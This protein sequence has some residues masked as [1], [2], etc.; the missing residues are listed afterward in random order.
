MVGIACLQE[1]CRKSL[2]FRVFWLGCVMIY[3]FGE[4]ELDVDQFELRVN[5]AR[6]SVEPQVFVIL[7]LLI[8][9]R[10]RM[11][12]KS[13]LMDAVWNGR[14]VSEGAVSSRIRSAR[15]AV[16]DTG[17]AQRI[18][19]TVHG[20]G[21]R[22]VADVVASG[23]PSVDRS[24]QAV[25]D[26]F[27]GF[28]NE[29]PN[30]DFQFSLPNITGQP[31]IAV[32]PFDQIT[33]STDEAI[34]AKGLTEETIANLT[35]F[36]DLFVF[37]RSTTT[38]L[39]K[40]GADI[41]EL[42]RQLGVDFVLE[43]SVRLAGSK[44]KITIQLIDAKSDIHVFA[45]QYDQHASPDSLYDLQD[46]VALLVAGRIADRYGPLSKFAVERNRTGQSEHWNTYLQISR[47]YDYYETR[48]ASIHASVKAGLKAAL[49]EDRKSS[50][51]WAALALLHVDE[52]RLPFHSDPKP[53]LL[54]LALDYAEKSVACD[55]EN[56]FAYLARA[57]A[58]FHRKEFDDFTVAAKR[59]VE[60]NPG[61]AHNLAEIAF[62]YC[63]VSDFEQALPLADRAV[64]LSPVHPGWFRL[65]RACFHF[66]TEKDAAAAIAEQKKTPMEGYFWYHAYMVA[67]CALAGDDDLTK[68]EVRKILELYPDFPT[69]VFKEAEVW[70][71]TGAMPLKMLKGWRIAGLDVQFPDK[72][73]HLDVT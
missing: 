15:S 49:F 35:R 30:T 7:R 44:I 13:E 26:A 36:K 55:G 54:D 24:D 59:C 11:V 71:V 52:Y 12:S 27:A 43:G 21:L 2:D 3:T 53:E 47:F 25:P 45:E 16:G 62:C 70:C 9:N 1:I 66:V 69:R 41:P 65:T 67:Y 60:I 39:V 64:E 31:S 28:S 73:R 22:F 33:G 56:S 68:A 63:L 18:I 6:I 50:D 8:E 20:Q 10:E 37:S 42:Q 46:H 34:F 40:D 51:A 58:R 4:F 48:K 23:K 17:K 38:K 32:L 57:L 61:H 29:F 72:Y 5:G 19:R 14:I